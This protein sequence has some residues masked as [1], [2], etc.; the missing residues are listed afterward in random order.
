MGS[1]SN[2][3]RSVELEFSLRSCGDTFAID[4][5]SGVL[6]VRNSSKLDYEAVTEFLVQVEAV[7][8]QWLT[9]LR[10]ERAGRISLLVRLNNVNDNEPRFV[11]K[12][13]TATTSGYEFRIDEN[14]W[15]LP[16]ALVGE[17]IV[18]VD[19][20]LTGT[21]LDTSISEQLVPMDVRLLGAE[22]ALFRLVALDELSAGGKLRY[23]LEALARFDHEQKSSYTFQV[24]VF[25]GKYRAHVD[26]IVLV[27]D[28][29]DNAPVFRP[30]APTPYTWRVDE[31]APTGTLVGRVHAVDADGTRATS[32]VAYKLVAVASMPNMPGSGSEKSNASSA[33]LQQQQ[34]FTQL[35]SVDWFALDEETG[36]VRVQD[37]AQLD[38]ERILAFKLTILA[39]NPLATV[40]MSK[41]SE[42]AQQ[43]QQQQQLTSTTWAFV[44]LNDVNDNWP[45]LER[46]LITLSVREK[47]LALPRH[48]ATVSARDPDLA[49][50]GTIKYRIE[51]INGRAL[52][53]PTSN[54]NNN[55]NN[56]DSNTNTNRSG[57]FF[58][59]NAYTGQL[60]LNAYLD[61][62]DESHASLWS[63][64][65][66]LVVLAYDLGRHET[67]TSKCVV[68]IASV[69]VNDHAP[70]LLKPT[71]P[72][73][74]IIGQPTSSTAA[75][76]LS[77][78]F[79]TRSPF[80]S[81]LAVISSAAVFQFDE[82]SN[83]GLVKLEHARRYLTDVKCADP[84]YTHARIRYSI[85]RD[86]NADWTYFEVDEMSGSLYS[87]V[88]F[89]YEARRDFHLKLTCTDAGLAIDETHIA[90]A[91]RDRHL[92][93]LVGKQIQTLH[94][95]I[96]HRKNQDKNPQKRI[97]TK[98]STQRQNTQSAWYKYK[99][100]LLTIFFFQ[101]ILRPRFFQFFL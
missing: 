72:S 36:E 39:Y 3:S 70:L 76:S 42:N 98:Q 11:T 4:K 49:E 19:R 14:A 53:I 90:L 18:I 46:E 65:F 27:T 13:A 34:Q 85:E 82:E 15:P 78:P 21:V 93:S 61:M 88:K 37:A 22:S 41:N 68:H 62:D 50:N 64:S 9:E 28:L 8:R 12:A 96:A 2:A 25:D 95:I 7:E 43:Q 80:T 69:D 58:Y 52:A 5:R 40:E 38:R 87:V 59:M 89:D 24:A 56:D 67:R 6:S 55:N 51:S 63:A 74:P 30:A 83:E 48:I 75:L 79:T 20:D 101:D 23:Q 84:D 33:N 26:C 71:L 54:S 29:N 81:T 35:G 16:R 32:H 94:L 10:Q 99:T 73:L 77:S 60:Y 66:E 57:E 47:L 17:L 1:A 100:D 44:Y 91:S 31:N 45:V 92:L 97:Y 86:L